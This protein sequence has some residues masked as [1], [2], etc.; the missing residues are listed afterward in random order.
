MKTTIVRTIPITD[1]NTIYV[2]ANL[3]FEN[4]TTSNESVRE[5]IFVKIE[6]EDDQN[7]EFNKLFKSSTNSFDQFLIRKIREEL[8]DERVID[9]S[10]GDVILYSK[11]SKTFNTNISGTNTHTFFTSFRDS[12]SSNGNNKEKQNDKPSSTEKGK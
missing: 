10:I 6:F 1:K 8:K 3:K 9:I 2:V 4:N 12:N 7:V 5:A 11:D